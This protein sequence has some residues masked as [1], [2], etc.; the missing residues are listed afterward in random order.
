[1]PPRWLTRLPRPDL[2][3]LRGR[4]G[5]SFNLIYCHHCCS[6][7]ALCTYGT[8]RRLKYH[9]SVTVYLHLTY[10]GKVSRFNKCLTSVC[11]ANHFPPL[12]ERDIHSRQSCH[13][14]PYF[15]EG[16][17]QQAVLPHI[18]FSKRACT[19]MYP[20]SQNERNKKLEYNTHNYQKP[21]HPIHS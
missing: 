12:F 18:L 5:L 14:S 9:H 11:A 10:C 2:L 8:Q 16:R 4:S 20:I 17:W 3:S 15:G 21:M 1:M 19:V 7:Y 6:T 13:T